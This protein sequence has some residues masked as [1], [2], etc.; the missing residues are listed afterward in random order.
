MTK[1][2]M[3]T[4]MDIQYR[5]AFVAQ[6]RIRSGG[7]R[8]ILPASRPDPSQIGKALALCH[9]HPFRWYGARVDRDPTGPSTA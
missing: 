2:R 5:A 9:A 7:L 3:T 4:K 1:M 8:N 6:S